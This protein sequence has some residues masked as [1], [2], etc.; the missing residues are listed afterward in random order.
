MSKEVDW[1][2]VVVEETRNTHKSVTDAAVSRIEELLERQLT[3]RQIPTAELR[4]LAT[5]LISDMVPQQSKI[6]DKDED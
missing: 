6:E 5:A 2:Q 4:S 3:Q 1:I